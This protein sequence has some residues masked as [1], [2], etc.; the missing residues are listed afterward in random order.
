MK[1]DCSTMLY[2]SVVAAS[3]KK[4]NMRFTSLRKPNVLFLS[5]KNLY[6]YYYTPVALNFLGVVT[7]R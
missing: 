7:T 3:D 2:N 4:L 1:S 5:Y 6:S